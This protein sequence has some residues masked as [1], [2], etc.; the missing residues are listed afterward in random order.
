MMDDA[1]YSLDLGPLE[2]VPLFAHALCPCGAY[3]RH[4]D[5]AFT[6][7]RIDVPNESRSVGL[8]TSGMAAKGDSSDAS[9][10]YPDS[11]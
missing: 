6:D 4:S 1:M 2:P 8:T 9:E 5:C 11:P 3:W 10:V 7:G